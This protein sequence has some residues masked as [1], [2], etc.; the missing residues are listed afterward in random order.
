M[1]GS[2][3]SAA[4]ASIWKL[5]LEYYDAA[6]AMQGTQTTSRFIEAPSLEMGV[7]GGGDGDG[8][9]DDD[10]GDGDDDAAARIVRF[11]AVLHTA[12][13][14]EC[15]ADT[16]GQ[17][18]AR[19]A[20]VPA[21]GHVAIFLSLQGRVILTLTLG[22]ALPAPHAMMWHGAARGEHAVSYCELPQTVFASERTPRVAG[23]PTRPCAV[24]AHPSASV[25]GTAG[26][27]PWATSVSAEFVCAVECA[28]RPRDAAFGVPELRLC[29]PDAAAST[30]ARAPKRARPDT[31][32]ATA[33]ATTT[34]TATA[35]AEPPPPTAETWGTRLY[36][37]VSPDA[38]SARLGEAYAL[39]RITIALARGSLDYL[40][41]T[42]ELMS[43]CGAR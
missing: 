20:L 18:H 12:P 33:T 14:V 36:G 11:T 28:H 29:R 17:L 5:R 6:G 25:L 21:R 8:D 34:A 32:T 31:A 10:D 39:S 2:V 23:E 19:H 1:S 42:A 9:G 22:I 4:P 43:A 26:D 40:R 24:P 38:P 37:I 27:W 13:A 16:H 35:T 41:H 7:V 30:P 15:A 3:A